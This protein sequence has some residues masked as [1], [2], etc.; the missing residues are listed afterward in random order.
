MLTSY[1]RVAAGD[2]VPPTVRSGRRD[3]W[4]GKVLQEVVA[5][6]YVTPLREGGSLPG[7]VEADDLGTYVMK[8]STWWR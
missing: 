8:L 5:T 7:I 1:R 6:R 4:P 2:A 3:G